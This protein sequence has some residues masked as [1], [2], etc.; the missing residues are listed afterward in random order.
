MTSANHQLVTSCLE[1]FPY[2][3]LWSCDSVLETKH[4]LLPMGYL[5]LPTKIEIFKLRSPRRKGYH[6]LRT[7]LTHLPKTYTKTIK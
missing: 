6:L 4:P 3:W 5:G 1:V 2:G 7:L